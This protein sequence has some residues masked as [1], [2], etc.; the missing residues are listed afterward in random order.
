MNAKIVTFIYNA[1]IVTPENTINN[2]WIRLVDGHIEAI[3]SADE[4][5]EG[6]RLSALDMLRIANA[7][8]PSLDEQGTSIDTGAVQD[9]MK[10][11]DGH[12]GWV[13]PGFID[14]H[15]HGG[16]G[17]DFMDAE[18]AGLDAIT[19]FHGLH[20]TTA[21]LATTVTAPKVDL[22]RVLERVTQYRETPMPYARLLGVHLEGP[23]ISAKWPGAQNPQYIVPPQHAWLDEWVDRFPGL[24]R[25]QT[26]APETEGALAY[27]E[28]LAREGIVAAL[29]HTDATYEQV[30]LAV[31]HGLSHAVHTFNAMRMLHHREP[32]TVGA[33]MSN[34]GIMAEVIADGHHVHPICINMIGQLKGPDNL[35]LITDAISAAGLGDGI[36]RLGGLDVVVK[37]SVARLKEGDSLAGST[38]TMIDAFRYVVQRAGFPIDYASRMASGNPARRLGIEQYTGALQPGK[39]ADVLLLDEHLELQRVWVHGQCIL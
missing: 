12:N 18:N 34:P 13:L 30:E 7:P 9:H 21:M 38:L 27:I 10:V 3:G 5:Q 23:F 8:N 26:L 17:H 1:N 24:I 37:D 32:G 16:Y 6:S 35:I 36:Y 15:V 25:M 28:A 20:G 22:D 33:V 19:R 31:R 2:G 14:I 4:A 39:Q 29:G 11:I